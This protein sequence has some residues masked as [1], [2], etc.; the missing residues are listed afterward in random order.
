MRHPRAFWLL[1]VLLAIAALA[2][3]PLL[4]KTLS[5]EPQLIKVDNFLMGTLVETIAWDPHL[6][7][8]RIKEAVLRSFDPMRMVDEAM[9]LTVAQSW[10]NKVNS[11][12]GVAP[13]RVPG[14][15]LQVI[16]AAQGVSKLSGGAFDITIGA[17]SALWHFG[18]TAG[19]GPPDAARIR[20]RLGLVDWSL[21]TASATEGTVFLP[22]KGMRI[23]LGG[24]AKGYAV[25]LAAKALREAGL[26]NFIVNA[27]GDL[28]A[29][30][31]RRDGTSWRI[32]VRDPRATDR[33]LCTLFVSDRAVV[34]S[35]D[36]EQ[37]FTYQ[38]KRYHHILDPRTGYPCWRCKSATVIAPTAEFA[39]ALA[40]AVFV[41][42]PA[43]GLEL[44][45]QLDS[46]E[47][48]VVDSQGAQHCSRGLSRYLPGG[49]WQSD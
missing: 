30:G 29:A 24:I 8:S 10:V 21:I 9:S 7:E 49:L 41:M 16:R 4:R 23:D 22:V 34:T 20:D 32:G 48:I 1:F 15:V 42:G 43:K 12:S 27:G 13:V 5:G 44:V 36:Y 46:V 45:D 19:A 3:V 39:D 26:S 37:F 28:Y 25:D 31:R 35:G 17:V 18:D 33:L 47:A 6:G 38:G 11:S 14:P 2:M 40:T